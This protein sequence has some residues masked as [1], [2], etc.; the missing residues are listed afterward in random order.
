M[1][2]DSSKVFRDYGTISLGGANAGFTSDA[3]GGLFLDIRFYRTPLYV[4]ER[5]KTKIK[6]LYGGVDV[7]CTLFMAQHDATVYDAAFMEF[8]SGSAATISVGTKVPGEEWET[9][10]FSFVGQNVSVVG[11]KVAISKAPEDIMRLGLADENDVPLLCEFL[12]HSDGTL[13]TITLL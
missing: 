5:G 3:R 7:S 1:G 2:V 6:V 11:S 4:H 12:P 8:F 9:K 10:A 13:C